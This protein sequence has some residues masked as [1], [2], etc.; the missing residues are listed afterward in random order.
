MINVLF[1]FTLISVFGFSARA[2]FA[3]LKRRADAYHSSE[4]NVQDVAAKRRQEREA[5]APIQ[6]R[7][8]KRAVNF[9][10]S[11]H[12]GLAQPML[13]THRPG[14]SWIDNISF[15]TRDHLECKARPE[16][17][18]FVCYNSETLEQTDFYDFTGFLR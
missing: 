3:D 17:P 4:Q 6:N 16:I 13:I 1:T 2:E 18:V 9:L 7:N 5:Y 11:K 12:K 8:F 14:E 15:V 10:A